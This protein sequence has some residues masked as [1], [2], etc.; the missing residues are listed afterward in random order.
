MGPTPD[1]LRRDIDERRQEISRD[2]DA[3]GDKVSPRQA[4]RR[5]TASAR[6]RMH[7]LRDNVMG[8]ASEGASSVSNVASTTRD[9]VEQVPDMARRQVEGSPLAVGMVAFGAGLLLA[10]LLQPTEREQQLASNAQPGLERAAHEL[11]RSG[12]EMA[13]ELQEP[14]REAMQSAGE[15]VREAAQSVASGPSGGTA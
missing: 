6:R 11:R 3:I 7:D 15:T 5:S 13:G 12:E 4:A 1:E 14:A 8:T 9:Q 2:L 10:A